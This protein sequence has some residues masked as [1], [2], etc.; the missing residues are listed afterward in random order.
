[1]VSATR[2][3][4]QVNSTIT[5]LFAGHLSPKGSHDSRTE[6]ED[7]DMPDESLDYEK[8]VDG[9]KQTSDFTDTNRFY[10][11]LRLLHIHQ[12]AFSTPNVSEDALTR[13][14]V[15][16]GLLLAHPFPTTYS[17][18]SQDI[19]DL[20][21]IISDSV[22][23]S[24]QARCLHM[25]QKQHRLKD[26]RLRYIFAFSDADEDTW[27]QLSTGPTSSSS[28]RQQTL[29]H[30]PIRKWETMQDATPLMTENDT[31]I[32]LSLFGARKSVL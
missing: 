7:P 22:S 10:A 23:P 19:C 27:L 1:M 25:L 16:L 20:L 13:L 2:I 29:H 3:I 8:S 24:I 6:A 18:L 11:L 5:H 17:Y 28:T 15:L 14:L 32:S 26:P 4:A 9:R 12:T 30:F 21:T 31:S